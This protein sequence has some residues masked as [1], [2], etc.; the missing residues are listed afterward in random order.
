[1]PSHETVIALIQAYGLWV[2]APFAILEGPIVT[3]VASYLAHQGALNLIG[4][5]WVCVAG[6]L[7]GDGLIYALGRFG[8]TAL[9]DR[10]ARWLGLSQ[11]RK[12]ALGT[13]FATKGGRT[14]LFGKWT[15]SA[16][17]PIMLASG[18][19]HMNFASYLW[20]N[21]LGSLP[22][23][24]LFCAI[25]YYLGAAYSAIDGYIYRGSAALLALGLLAITGYLLHQRRQA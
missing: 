10:V 22:K 5:F 18:L 3:V 16:G 11:A 23:T 17:L 9:P 7:I 20:Y 12:L 24:L 8:A 14:L 25:G 15:H 13:H 1:M 21:L 6:D 2:L 19:A 4:V